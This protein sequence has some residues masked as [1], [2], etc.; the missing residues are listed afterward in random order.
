[1]RAVS[2]VVQIRGKEK[3][4]YWESGCPLEQASFTREAVT[5]PSLLEFKEHL[6]VALS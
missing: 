1:M 2:G 5:E 3:V 4:L 6:G